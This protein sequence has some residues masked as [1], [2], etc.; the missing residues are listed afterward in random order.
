MK[1]RWKPRP[2][3][4]RAVRAEAEAYALANPRPLEQWSTV[5]YTCPVH[6]EH[7]SS[8]IGPARGTCQRTY[9]DITGV[10][11]PLC[12]RPVLSA[13]VERTWLR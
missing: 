7:R 5:V 2:V 11:M 6:G 4:Y 9:A 1:R 12:D 8:H 13:V 10:A 3:D